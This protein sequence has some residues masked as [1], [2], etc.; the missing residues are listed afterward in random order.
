MKKY[1]PV[2]MVVLLAGC[3]CPH[4]NAHHHDGMKTQLDAIRVMIKQSALMAVHAACAAGEEKTMLIH[5]AAVQDR[6][7]MGG[8][9]MAKI[10]K[11]MNMQPNAS[12]G[13]TM[14]MG[15]ND[16]MSAEMKM[17][18]ALHDAGEDVFDLLD[19]I[20]ETPGI[21]CRQVAPAAMAASAAMLR[22]ASTGEAT[23]DETISSVKKLDARASTRLKSSGLPDTVKAL[24]VVLQAI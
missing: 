5:A 3:S 2:V 12:G 19:G 13:M 8:P 9:E 16:K 22:E 6:R 17:H 18:V 24:T 7:A 21:S 11:M 1:M 15:N 4:P 23:K 10:H 20:G 14:N